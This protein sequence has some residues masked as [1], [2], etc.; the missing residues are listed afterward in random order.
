MKD[1]ISEPFLPAAERLTSLFPDM[2][3]KLLQAQM[4][5]TPVRHLAESVVMGIGTMIFFG[6]I[7]VILGSNFGTTSLL[8]LSVLIAPAAGVL[9][10]LIYA[11][12]PDMKA[13]RRVQKLERDLPYALR[14]LLIEVQSGMNL[15][16]AMVSISEGYGEASVEFQRIVKDINAGVSE[17][18]ALEKAVIRNPSLQFRRSLW[19]M[20]NTIKAGSDLGN[21][22]ESLVDAIMTQQM[23][24]V[25]R[26]GQEL[27]PYILFYLI[28]A[29]IVPS[30][31]ASFLVIF[32]TF[33]GGNVSKPMFYMILVSIIGFQIMFLQ[34]VRTKRPE[35]KI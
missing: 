9:G 22:L 35:V 3:R 33:T 6:S 2:E 7:F 23:T 1:K 14:H 32:S 15:Y 31:G 11:K 5:T 30:L 25:K 12:Y 19:Q 13:R 16:E 17:M 29:V 18:E 8:R 27:N 26:Y 4:D 20:I 10:F 34:V 24:E 28:V 21:T